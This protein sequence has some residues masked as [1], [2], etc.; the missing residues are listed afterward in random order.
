MG[1]S[2]CFLTS[3]ALNTT[4]KSETHHPVSHSCPQY[5]SIERGDHDS[6]CSLCGEVL[7]KWGDRALSWFGGGDSSPSQ[8]HPQ[9]RLLCGCRVH[10]SLSRARETRFRPGSPFPRRPPPRWYRGPSW[11]IP[12]RSGLGILS[13][14][15][16]A[17]ASV[18]DEVETRKR[19][20]KTPP[21]R[22]PHWE[23]PS[24]LL[25][26]ERMWW[27]TALREVVAWISTESRALRGTFYA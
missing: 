27:S 19:A 25:I 22:W 26:L 16:A 13:I 21:L 10:F 8:R 5:C 9:R 2:N 4:L 17:V 7:D 11:R 15:L 18:F 6:A 1:C 20:S 23:P 12:I 14:L 24:A 3:W